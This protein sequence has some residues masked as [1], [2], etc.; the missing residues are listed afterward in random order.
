MLA[1]LAIPLQPDPC[2]VVGYQTHVLAAVVAVCI[3]CTRGHARLVKRRD[4]ASLAGLI[5]EIAELVL[6]VSQDFRAGQVGRTEHPVVAE[7][8]RICVFVAYRRMRVCMRSCMH[9][10]TRCL[11]ASMH[12]RAHVCWSRASRA[13]A[14]YLSGTVAAARQERHH[15]MRTKHAL[16]RGAGCV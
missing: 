3:V 5:P 11:Y 10:C 7:Q 15:V 8:V 14:I 4:L 16:L 1:M 13:A 6:L 9:A 2:N 12:M